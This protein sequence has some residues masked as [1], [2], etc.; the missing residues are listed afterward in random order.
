MEK[1]ILEPDEL[2]R[3]D[4]QIM[5]PDFGEE[6]QIK[7]KNS[8]IFI[9]GAG[10]LG[11]PVLLYLSA[12]GIGN[13]RVADNDKVELSNL[14]RQIIH[15][16]GDIN[17]KKVISAKE[18]LTKV[19]NDVNIEVIEDTLTNDNINEHTWGCDGIVD[20]MDN[21]ATRLTLNR[22]SIKW[23]IPLFHGAV[24]GLEGRISTF[25]PGKTAC[26]ACMYSHSPE[27]SKFPVLGVTP[28]IIGVL[29]ATEV[30]KYI[31][32][33]GDMLMNRLLVYDGLD[34]KFKEFQIKRNP[35]CREC[36]S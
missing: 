18:K 27:S 14:N 9:A 13:I 1:H 23:S 16:E 2:K 22:A 29:Q 19:N 35:E 17:K 5:I 31:L 20:A 25:I 3:Y 33:M 15:W 4:R 24:S 8:R 12:A 26:L 6:G 36:R 30:I 7:L 28:G 32:G 10:G 34:L 21:F 11:S